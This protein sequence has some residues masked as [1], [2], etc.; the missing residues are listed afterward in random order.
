MKVF[1]SGATGFIGG[2]LALKLA[3]SAVEIHALYRDI[4]KTE[5]IRHEKIKWFQGD[6]TDRQSL[7]MAMD[8]CEQA[9]HLGAFATLLIRRPETI[10]QQNVQGT[11]NL[12]ECARDLGLKRVVFVSTA[13]VLGP[14]AGEPL[15][16]NTPYPANMFTHYTM[17][18]ALAEQKVLEFVEKGMDI[19]IVNPTRVYGPGILSRSNMATLLDQYIRGKWHFRPGNGKGTGN[20]VYV[21]DV[22]DGIIRAME[23]GGKGERYILGGENVSF[24]ELFAIVDRITGRKMFL[25]SI[26]VF[27]IVWIASLFLFIARLSGWVPPFTPDVVK[28]YKYNWLVS[29]EKA[30]SGLGYKPLPLENGLEITIKWLKTRHTH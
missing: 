16:E 12:L 10:Y 3:D 25:I 19:V 14:S 21:D 17:S 30:R 6:L 4:V 26:P 20:Y 28:R 23:K 29:S 13:G 15:D 5:G 22:S 8:G 11:V 7:A 24:D 18:K 9:Y 27:V 2:N 1:I